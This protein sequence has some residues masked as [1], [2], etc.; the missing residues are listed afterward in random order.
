MYSY[1][2]RKKAVEL[3][4]KYDLC[5]ASTVRELGYPNRRMLVCWY[6]EYVQTGR[7]HERY[8]KKSRYTE[9]QMRAAVSYY[10][11]HGRNITRTV[12][13]VGYPSRETLRVWIEELAPEE[14]KARMRRSGVVQFSKEQKQDAV[15]ELCTRE[16][17]AADIATKFGASRISLYK[18]KKQLLGEEKSKTMSKYRKTTLPDDRDS[19]LVEVESL[20]KQ[21]YRQQMEL[22]ILNKAAEIIKKTRASILENWR[23]GRKPA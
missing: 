19:L 2:D 23:T 14:R 8:K 6:N 21:I 11:E 7:L 10:L 12:R 1:E 15:I 5:A 3:Y 16:G 9:A 4:I 22:D 17:S 13:A 18:W 20:K